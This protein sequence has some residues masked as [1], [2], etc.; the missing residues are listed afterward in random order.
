[1]QLYLQ[2]VIGA[3]GIPPI[4]R[5][6]QLQLTGGAAADTGGVWAGRQ[7][8][9]HEDSR[10]PPA[11]TCWADL[12]STASLPAQSKALQEER[13]MC[14]TIT[15]NRNNKFMLIDVE[16]KQNTYTGIRWHA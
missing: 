8:F 2:E 7:Y 6:H 10:T 5:Q 12:A 1:M 16:V 4:L 3:V 14:Q 11:G 9:R 15:T 13:N